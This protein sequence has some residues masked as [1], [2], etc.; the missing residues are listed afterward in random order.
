MVIEQHVGVSQI[1]RY[2]HPRS[3]DNVWNG[4]DVFARN[5]HSPSIAEG[6]Q[7]QLNWVK[8]SAVCNEVRMRSRAI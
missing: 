3:L 6:A 8:L 4:E 1:S 2:Q 7:A 5:K